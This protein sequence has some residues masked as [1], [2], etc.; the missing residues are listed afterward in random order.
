[1]GDMNPFWQTLDS[2]F[3]ALFNATTPESSSAYT[4]YFHPVSRGQDTHGMFTRY[5]QG[6]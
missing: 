2:V 5:E 4:S 6:T 3:G 1:M